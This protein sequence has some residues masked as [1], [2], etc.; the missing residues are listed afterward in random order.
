MSTEHTHAGFSGVR[1]P[2]SRTLV[3]HGPRQNGSHFNVPLPK[4]AGGYDV[5]VQVRPENTT[6]ARALRAM[7]STAGIC[8][9]TGYVCPGDN[10]CPCT[11][12]NMTVEE[13]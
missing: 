13:V 11:S 3:W 7:K 9:T 2:F 12:A 10:I 1:P 6:V 8:P 4:V 5:I